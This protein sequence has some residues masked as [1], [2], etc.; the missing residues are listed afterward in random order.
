MT[1]VPTPAV[2]APELVEELLEPDHDRLDGLV[3]CAHVSDGLPEVLS[4]LQLV[5]QP[6]HSARREDV[7]AEA[8]EAVT[9]VGEGVDDAVIGRRNGRTARR[10]QL[11]SGRHAGRRWQHRGRGQRR[12]IEVDAEPQDGKRQAQP[13]DRYARRVIVLLTEQRP[14]GWP[15]GE[16]A[17]HE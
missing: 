6:I 10:R 3:R 15:D 9:D 5:D 14:P 2:V 16:H 17:D 12:E 8:G 4:P 13:S 1:S 7:V 11:R